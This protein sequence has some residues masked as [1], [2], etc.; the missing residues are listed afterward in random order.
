MNDNSYFITHFHIKL[1][2]AYYAYTLHNPLLN[3]IEPGSFTKLQSIKIHLQRSEE[4]ATKHVLVFLCLSAI[5]AYSY[6]SEKRE[7]HYRHSGKA[8]ND[9][10]LPFLL[11]TSGSP[12]VDTALCQWV[13]GL[14]TTGMLVLLQVV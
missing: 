11:M 9:F 12:S 3:S 4:M 14:A 7:A 8:D 10:L 5:V 1:P 13:V 6:C 2:P